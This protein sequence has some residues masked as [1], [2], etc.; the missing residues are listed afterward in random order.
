MLLQAALNGPLTKDDHPAVPVSA[1]ELARD[2]AACVA[3]GA[4]SVHLHP[5][6]AEGVERADGET[7]D[8]VVRQVRAACPAGISVT[9]GAWI[10]PDLDRRLE[11][12]RGWREPDSATVN[13]SEHG[14]FAVMEALLAA[15]VAIEAGVWT[16]DDAVRLAESGL[17]D[18]VT[19]ILVEPVELRAAE[20]VAFVDAIHRT[21]DE[22]GL[23]A[24]RLQ[25]GDGEATWVLI[26]DA[27]RRGLATRV[28]LEDT[29]LG[30][31]GEPAAGNAALVEAARTLR[32]T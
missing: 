25:H 30:P 28:G 7:V 16:T 32:E 8:A 10:E 27:L 5:R 21:I 18:R 1:H 15:G 19:R 26:A 29:L 31:D 14:A 9:T 3:A 24:P 22:L 17:A 23:G 11:L 6:D 12:I 13:V 2:A 20:A 4:W